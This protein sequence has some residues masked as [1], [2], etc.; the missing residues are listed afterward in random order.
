[1]VPKTSKVKRA[2]LGMAVTLVIYLP[3]GFPRFH[4]AW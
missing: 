4:T 3:F 1:M 2:G